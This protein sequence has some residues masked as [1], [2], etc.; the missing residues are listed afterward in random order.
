MELTHQTPAN[1]VFGNKIETFRRMLIFF[2]MIDYYII[3]ILQTLIFYKEVLY[4]QA[5]YLT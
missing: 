1:I 4:N 2:Y 3:S 5:F